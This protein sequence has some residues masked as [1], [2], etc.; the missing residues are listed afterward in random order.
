M[1]KNQSAFETKV[2]QKLLTLGLDFSSPMMLAVAVSG[3]ADSISLL[4]CLSK[5]L[6]KNIGLKVVTV[7]HNLREKSETEGDAVFVQD[8]CKKLGVECFRYDLPRGQV[9]EVSKNFDCGIED[10]ARRLRYE[11]FEDFRN[12]HKIDYICLAHNKNDQLET[13]LM[14]FLSGGD[15]NALGGIPEKRGYFLRPLIEISRMEIENYLKSLGVVYRTDSTNFDTSFTRNRIRQNLVP[16]LDNEF[17]GWQSAVMNLS[18]KLRDDG[19]ALDQILV[20]SLETIHYKNLGNDKI[21]FDF[22]TFLSLSPSI[23]RKIV[24]RAIDFVGAKKRVP[25]DFVRKIC[26]STSP[27]E[28]ASSGIKVSLENDLVSVEKIKKQATESA[29]FAIIKTSGTYDAGE[30]KILVSEGDRKIHLEIFGQDERK[31]VISVPNLCFPFVIRS[32]QVDD[33][34]LTSNGQFK[35]VSRILEDWKCKVSHREKIILVQEL[36]SPDQNLVALI[37][38]QMSYGDW[39]LK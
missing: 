27:M 2:G 11:I 31:S 22:K 12:Q 35:S 39:I 17:P 3:G 33:Q 16:F 26:Q 18:E 15:S 28:I 25:Y 1:N 7:N 5:I 30:W 38:S 4:T 21:V 19:N 9:E 29:F 23:K 37:G 20:E 14:R 6:P 10:G 32:R 13:V 36:S 8:Y 34:I 24:Y